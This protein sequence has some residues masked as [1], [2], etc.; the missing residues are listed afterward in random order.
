MAQI[1]EYCILSLNSSGVSIDYCDGKES[2][3]QSLTARGISPLLK[4]LGGQGWELVTVVASSV[5]AN[6]FFKRPR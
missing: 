2:Q 4:E 3:R 1:W 5:G 6:Y